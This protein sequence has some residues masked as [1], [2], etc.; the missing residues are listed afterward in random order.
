MRRYARLQAVKVL[1][2]PVA[3]WI[4]ARGFA[5]ASDSSRLPMA[6]ACTGQS[7]PASSG[8]MACKRW[9]RFPAVRYA[10]PASAIP[11]AAG[12]PDVA[13][14]STQRAR[15]SGVW[16]AKTLRLRGSG[17]QQV[18]EARLQ[19]G[20]FVEERQRSAVG[21]QNIRQPVAVLAGLG[22]DAGERVAG[23]LGLHDAGRVLIDVQQVIGDAVAGFQAELAHGNAPCGVDVHRVS[24]LHGPTC[25]LKQGVNL[26]AGFL[27]GG[28]HRSVGTIRNRNSR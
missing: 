19:S 1:P 25:L 26:D 5:S 2:L 15:A 20:G 4:N 12:I 8:G 6:R 22:L 17:L 3:I 27:F 24:V 10:L 13:P 16:K 7:A 9:R 28:G 23:R 18:G 11:A 14:E 21:G